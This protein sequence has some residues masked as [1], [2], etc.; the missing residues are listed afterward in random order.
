MLSKVPVLSEFMESSVDSSIVSIAQ[1]SISDTTLIMKTFHY[2]KV[3]FITTCR[4]PT[5][6]TKAVTIATTRKHCQ[7]FVSVFTHPKR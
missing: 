6:C 4:D 7:S 3:V 5:D 2:I 1:Y